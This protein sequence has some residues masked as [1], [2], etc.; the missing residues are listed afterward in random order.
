[1]GVLLKEEPT[2]TELHSLISKVSSYPI[3]ANRLVNLAQRKGM[4]NA[5]V[6]F[7]KDFPQDEI[8]DD[9]DDLLSRTENLEILHHQTAPKEEMHAPEED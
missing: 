7:Y 8:F 5:V 2:L 6:N 9:E 1:M 4:S 3:A